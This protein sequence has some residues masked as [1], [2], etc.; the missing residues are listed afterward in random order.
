MVTLW[1][2]GE[3][4]RLTA[5]LGLPSIACLISFG[6]LHFFYS[7]LASYRCIS[8]LLFRYTTPCKRLLDATESP[9]ISHFGCIALA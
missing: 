4:R 7:S 6:T 8:I 9:F 3:R 5:R 2:R 1:C